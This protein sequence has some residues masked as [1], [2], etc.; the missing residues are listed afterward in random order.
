[1]AMKNDDWNTVLWRL[2]DSDEWNKPELNAEAEI[3]NPEY[4][5]TISETIS[6]RYNE[7]RELSLSVHSHPELAFAE[8]KTHDILV[9]FMK[10][11]EGWK[12]TPN[13][14]LS[15]AWLAT[16]ASPEAKEDTRV[17]GI[18]SEMDALPKIGHACGHN[19]IAIAGVAIALG[20]KAVFE[21]HRLPGKII[22]LGTPAEERGHGKLQLLK[23]GAYKQMAACLMVH[24]AP[25]PRNTI[26]LTSCLA[27]KKIEAEFF[28]CAAHA[29][30]S[31]WE[32][33]NALD[34]AVLTYTNIA[35]L[36]QQVPS[37]CR[38]HSIF[39]GQDWALNIIPAYAKYI[40]VV[41]APTRA[42]QEEVMKKVLP[43]FEA[44]AKATGCTMKVTV[45]DGTYDLRQNVGLGKDIERT[46]G[47]K[48]G[49]V[50]R[51]RWGI[52]SASTDFG[53]VGYEL[54]SLHPGYAIPTVP[55]GGNHTT[56][57]TSAAATEEAHRATLDVTEALALTGVRVVLD[58]DWYEKEVWST[59]EADR[60]RREQGIIGIA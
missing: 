5:A 26:S 4:L 24:P 42:E 35:L 34:A 16:Y 8:H 57:F 55:D 29:A 23:A 19:L 37:A 18:N 54:P 17:I 53:N 44:A 28:G 59:F 15:T 47:A 11:Q 3:W 60:S 1:M 48:Y 45:H 39:E 41:R 7:L 46:F 10:K 40:A 30:L 20:I 50:E 52:K 12:V 25:G 36:R 13:F 21:R 14:E 22:L 31:P 58:Q 38:I 33:K 43:C 51:E 2:D 27:L 32:G 6:S 56:H 49:R 9:D